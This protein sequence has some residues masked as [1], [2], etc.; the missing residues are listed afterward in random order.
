MGCDVR[1][2]KGP[3]IFSEVNED[4]THKMSMSVERLLHLQAEIGDK[5]SRG[6]YVI[7]I[8]PCSQQPGIGDHELHSRVIIKGQ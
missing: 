6:D 5:V 2:M 8:S 7:A 1:R 4:S 3:S